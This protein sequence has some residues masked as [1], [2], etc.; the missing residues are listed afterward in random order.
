MNDIS[1]IKLTGKRGG[2]A[3]VDNA[4]F[5]KLNQWNWQLTE[6]GYVC[7]WQW[8]DGKHRVFRLHREVTG[9]PK[10]VKVDHSNRCPIDNTRRNLRICDL[11]QNGGNRAKQA[12]VSSSRFKGVSFIQRDSKWMAGIKHNGKS[13]NLGWYD[14]EEEAARAYNTKAAQIFGQFARLNDV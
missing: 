12:P 5:A 9:A 1:V 3:L 11:S 2:F 7:R 4:D 10:G 6:R 8:I 14:T 13:M